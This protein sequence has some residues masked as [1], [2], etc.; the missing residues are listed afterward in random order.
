[1]SF[2]LRVLCR[3]LTKDPDWLSDVFA[4]IAFVSSTGAFRVPLRTDGLGRHI[5]GLE[6]P[7]DEAV[8][9]TQQPYMLARFVY[10]GSI[11]FSQ[12][13]LLSLFPGAIFAMILGHTALD[14]AMVVAPISKIRRLNLRRAHRFGL[15]LVFACGI[16]V[17]AY[18]I[19]AMVAN[20]TTEDPQDMTW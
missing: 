20:I 2:V 6:L 12:M 17:C 1:M 8:Y 7:L 18:S 15:A 9:R 3:K 19:P 10:I 14:V 13:A 11:Y 5:Y 4:I 16:L